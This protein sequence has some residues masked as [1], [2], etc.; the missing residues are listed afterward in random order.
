LRAERALVEALGGGCQT[1]VGALAS[2]IESDELELVA[3]VVSL[4]GAR[5]VQ[6]NGRAARAEAVELGKR[7]AAELVDKGAADILAES[8]RAPGAVQGIQ[9]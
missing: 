5:S 8:R 3:A 2:M 1:P 4:D 9:P 6:A 7:V